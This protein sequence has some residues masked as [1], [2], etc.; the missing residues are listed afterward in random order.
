MQAADDVAEQQQRRPP[1]PLEVLDHQQQRALAGRTV[2]Y[3]GDGLEQP[4]AAVLALAGLRRGPAELGDERR[5]RLDVHPGE[6]AGVGRVVAQRL[7]E[8][9]VGHDGLLVDAAVQH[10]RAGLVHLGGEARRQP[11]LAHAGV[12][13]QHDDAALAG[14]RA[15]PAG[16]QDGELGLA[17]DE[18]ALLAAGEHDRER[19]AVAARVRGR[20]RRSPWRSSRS[21]SAVTCGAGVAPS[22]SRSSTRS[23][24]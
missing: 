17:A 11:R 9:L 20:R 16:A 2:E 13:R 3:G 1:R 15:L 8:R 21:L 18:R 12:A 5:E 14:G 23:W 22:S 19:D 4:V 10:D 7:H 6:V 24:S